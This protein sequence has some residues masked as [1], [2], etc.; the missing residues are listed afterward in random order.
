MAGRTRLTL[1]HVVARLRLPPLLRHMLRHALRHIRIS[2]GHHVVHVLLMLLLLVVVVL[3]LL[4]LPA[5]RWTIHLVLHWW[6]VRLTHV[7]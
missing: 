2:I 7:R 6:H 4:L 5:L 3:L 1:V